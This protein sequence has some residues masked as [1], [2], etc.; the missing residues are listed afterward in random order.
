METAL[1][2]L[3]SETLAR[4]AMLAAE[5][6]DARRGLQVLRM[7]DLAASLRVQ[8]TKL[9]LATAQRYPNQTR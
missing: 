6:G 7:G 8:N 2:E 9:A 3:I 1:D 5:L 4:I